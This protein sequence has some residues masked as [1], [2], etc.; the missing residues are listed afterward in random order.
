MS[1]EELME[2]ACRLGAQSA[3]N[4]WGGPFGTV[5][6]MNGEIV[7]RGQNSVLLTGDITS[8]G[9]VSAIRKAVAMLNPY[10]P[11][12]ASK[13]RTNRRWPS[14]PS[15]KARPMLSRSDRRCSWVWNFL[16]VDSRVPCA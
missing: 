16:P 13:N 8:H 4:G 15:L 10:A 9:E 3:A 1:P 14:P 2:E 7:A 12:S 11:R 6:A 5:I